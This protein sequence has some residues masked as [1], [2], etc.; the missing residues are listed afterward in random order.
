MSVARRIAYT[1]G[2]PLIP[3][4]R[5]ARLARDLAARSEGR[6]LVSCLHAVVA[7]LALDGLGQM[8]GY[9]LGAGRSG[10]RVSRYEFRRFLHVRPDERR[11]LWPA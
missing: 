1:L 6:S 7:G 8:M 3:P 9:A 2:A 10:T 11:A 4:L 5:L